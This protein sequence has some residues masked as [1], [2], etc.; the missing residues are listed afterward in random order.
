MWECRCAV[1]AA[2]E[3]RTALCELMEQHQVE[4]QH[5]NL[6]EIRGIPLAAL[7]G[8]QDSRG[9]TVGS[10]CASLGNQR[11]DAALGKQKTP[12]CCVPGS[13]EKLCGR[14]LCR[15]DRAR[16]QELTGKKIMF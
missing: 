9:S 5:Q 7:R 16:S 10:V 6:W 4:T 14:E 8:S 15:E 3:G 12:P 11:A 1:P 2:V 13:W